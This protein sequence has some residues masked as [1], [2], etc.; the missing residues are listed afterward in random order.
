MDLLVTV[1]EMP[2]LRVGAEAHP[3]RWTLP[4]GRTDTCHRMA[5]KV[6]CRVTALR[7]LVGTPGNWEKHQLRPITE[8]P[9]PHQPLPSST[10]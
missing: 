1:Q 7:V 6:D 3:S 4:E 5:T 9:L 2:Q 8:T 10:V